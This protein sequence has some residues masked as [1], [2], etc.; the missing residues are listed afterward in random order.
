[1]PGAPLLP[2]I[3]IKM[4]SNIVKCPWGGGAD[5][6]GE[7]LAS[8]IC[9]ECTMVCPTLRISLISQRAFD[10][11]RVEGNPKPDRDSEMLSTNEL[12]RAEESKLLHIRKPHI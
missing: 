3:I 8:K 9:L 4:S 1:M 10:G 6:G 2:G 12:W 11:P 5:L 7:P